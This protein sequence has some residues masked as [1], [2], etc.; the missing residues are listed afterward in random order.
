MARARVEIPAAARSAIAR[1]HN[2]RVALERAYV[3][4]LR[5]G[6]V[7]LADAVRR[8]LSHSSPWTLAEHARVLAELRKAGRTWG[9]GLTRTARAAALDAAD[10]RI[11]QVPRAIAALAAAALRSRI[12][13]P[14]LDVP[15]AQRDA[16]AHV[17][18]RTHD[19]GARA[20]E[21][22]GQLAAAQSYLETKVETPKP[23]PVVAAA[24]VAVVGARALSEG[25]RVLATEITAGTGFGGSAAFAQLVERAPGKLRK[26]WDATLDM[27]V[28]F[29]CK[30]AHHSVVDLGE[31]FPGV[32]VPEEPAHPNCRCCTG[33]WT[34]DWQSLVDE[35]GIGPAPRRGEVL[36]PSFASPAP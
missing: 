21:T 8:L 17:D 14:T 20:G 28:C 12:E 4:E 13:P 19:V 30:E 15:R 3:K 31:D 25:K 2:E 9:A 10:L 23:A 7:A 32:D 11:H 24:I 35:L 27:R 5:L 22:I 29:A 36:L 6:I 1:M 16:A 26:Y 18:A 34:D 33:P